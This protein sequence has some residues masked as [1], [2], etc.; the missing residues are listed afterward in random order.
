LEV[1]KGGR[2]NI[3]EDYGRALDFHSGGSKIPKIS[4]QTSP[5]RHAAGT[6]IL[7]MKPTAVA[8]P[9]SREGT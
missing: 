9:Q 5:V 2:T 3:R 8:T 6:A 1:G 7:V 4:G